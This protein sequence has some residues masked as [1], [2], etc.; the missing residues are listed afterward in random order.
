[1]LG[2]SVPKNLKNLSGS[3]LGI[4]FYL[5]RLPWESKI[6]LPS[7]SSITTSGLMK[8]KFGLKK[9][10]SYDRGIGYLRFVAG[11]RFNL[12][13]GLCLIK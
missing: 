2:F 7:S 5:I 12:R 13:V 11:G 9:R 1:M 10:M 4:G 6:G 8:V 3:S